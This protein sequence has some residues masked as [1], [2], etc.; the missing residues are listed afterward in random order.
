ME[1]LKEVLTELETLLSSI[2]EGDIS[3]D[4]DTPRD[5]LL[6]EL[7]KLQ[8]DVLSSIKQSVNLYKASREEP[9]L[10]SDIVLKDIQV[11][12]ELPLSKQFVEFGLWKTISRVNVETS[13]SFNRLNII[14]SSL[15]TMDMEEAQGQVE[16]AAEDHFKN[17]YLGKLTEGFGEELNQLRQEENFDGTRLEILIDSLQ[18][19]VNIFDNIEKELSLAAFK[20]T[21]A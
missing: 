18:S 14:E 16:T 3:L 17:F 11:N 5:T 10:L 21:K 20:Q 13:K 4:Q 19:T 8:L 9:D 15:D 12:S 1:E 2:F 7:P 6:E